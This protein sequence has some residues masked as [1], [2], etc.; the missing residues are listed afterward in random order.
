MLHNLDNDRII[1]KDY[2]PH[3]L[4]LYNADSRRIVHAS[5]PGDASSYGQIGYPA[6]SFVDIGGYDEMLPYPS[7]CQDCDIIKRLQGVGFSLTRVA[8]EAL[9]GWGVSN[10]QAANSNWRA[11]LR[12][13]VGCSSVGRQGGR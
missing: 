4:Q 6:K 10:D 1:G 12:A 3:V 9:A 11:H 8:S 7:G 2:V 13:K 5:V